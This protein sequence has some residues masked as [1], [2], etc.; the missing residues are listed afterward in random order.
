VTEKLH[1]FVG[2]PDTSGRHPRYP[3]SHTEAMLTTGVRYAGFWLRL[4]A[5]LID[6]VILTTA[7]TG[8][9][10]LVYSVVGFQGEG[11]GPEIFF[12][13]II[14]WPYF[15]IAESSKWQATLGKKL[16]GIIVTDVNGNRITFGRAN[17]RYWSKFISAVLLYIGFIMVAAT[18]RKQALHDLCASTLVVKAES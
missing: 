3:R 7:F 11:Q 15:T 8:L 14:P 12:V 2:R 13:P 10:L 18:R 6:G 4:L 1:V 17:A 9:T 5:A 16:V